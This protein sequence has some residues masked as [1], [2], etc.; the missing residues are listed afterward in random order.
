MKM[1]REIE[2]QFNK[3]AGEYD[4]NRRNLFPALMNFI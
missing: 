3:I 1:R 2:E 4:E